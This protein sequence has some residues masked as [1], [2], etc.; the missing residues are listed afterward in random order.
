MTL[1][2]AAL[3]AQIVGVV[4]VAATLIYL[5]MQVHQGAQQM[6]SEGRQAQ[7]TYDQTGVYKFVDFPELGRIFSQ[8]EK[9]GFEEKTKLFFWMIGQMRAREYEWLQYQNGA[10]T[11]ESWETYHGV[12]YFVLGTERSRALWEVCS[13]Y[14]NPGFVEMVGGMMKDV[15]PTDLWDR[16]EDVG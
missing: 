13:G 14:F 6:R 4:V 2:Q 16:L 5:A 3:I 11:R 10:I 8:A 12:I 7:L 1:E 9:P 15:P